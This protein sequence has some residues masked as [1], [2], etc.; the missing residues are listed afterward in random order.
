MEE[1]GEEEV[2]VVELLAEV[3]V[4]SDAAEE[5]M[6]DSVVAVGEAD[7]AEVV[8]ATQPSTVVVPTVSLF[9]NTWHRKCLQ[10]VLPNLAMIVSPTLLPHTR[11]PLYR[12][13]QPPRQLRF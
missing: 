10:T 13:R 5:A 1:G 2:E 9:T 11:T 4:E 12:V 7:D 6:V 3:D 8:P